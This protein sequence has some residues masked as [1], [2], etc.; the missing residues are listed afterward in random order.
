MLEIARKWAQTFPC[1][2]PHRSD[3]LNTPTSKPSIKT[4]IFEMSKGGFT[5]LCEG[6]GCGR[7]GQVRDTHP[8]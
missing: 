1:I 4:F 6:R 5:H 3:F 7:P 2:V 8:S